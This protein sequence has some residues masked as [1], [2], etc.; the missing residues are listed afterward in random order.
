MRQEQ[1]VR[2]LRHMD[3]FKSQSEV[4]RLRERSVRITQNTVCEVC[5][6]RLGDKVF[7]RYPNEVVVHGQ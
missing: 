4:A 1:I 7:V 6:K 3:H 2:W 5:G